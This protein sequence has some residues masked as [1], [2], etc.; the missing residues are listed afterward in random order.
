MTSFKLFILFIVIT[1][2]QH[3]GIIYRTGSRKPIRVFNPTLDDLNSSRPGSLFGTW[4]L[5]GTHAVDPSV[6]DNNGRPAQHETSKD[7]K[8]LMSFFPDSTF[9]R[10]RTNGE[11]AAGKWAYDSAN[12]SVF[13]TANRKTEEISIAFDYAAN[14]LKLMNFEFSP[15][16]N[17]SFIEYGSKLSR[18]QDDPYFGGNNQWRI[19]PTSP[20]T[21]QQIRNRLLNYLAHTSYILKSAQIREQDYI[22]WEFSE[23][24]VRLY[25][26]GIGV[27]AKDKIPASWLGSFYSVEEAHKAY[28]IFEDYLLKGKHKKYQSGN[29]VRDDLNILVDIR[30]GLSKK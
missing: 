21:D 29:W 20:E 27:V 18:Y 12:H 10:V 11:Y 23:G 13:L 28:A 16:K 22:S 7:N 15:G 1:M 3:R 25:N 2:L 30:Q 17:L 9:T 14:G 8:M 26:V 6:V 5:Y 24:I 4:R 19:K